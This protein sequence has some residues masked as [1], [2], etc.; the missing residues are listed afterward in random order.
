MFN[1]EYQKLPKVATSPTRAKLERLDGKGAYTFMLNP[2]LVQQDHK[3]NFSELGVLGTAQPQVVY[4]N[5]GTTLRL[6]G[7][8]ITTPGQGYSLEVLIGTLQSFTVP[9]VPGGSPPLLKFTYGKLLVPRCYLT[10]LSLTSSQWRSGDTVWAEA[11]MVLLYAPETPAPQVSKEVKL[12]P[13]EQEGN[14]NNVKIQL[15]SETEQKKWAVSP[16]DK[17]SID[18]KGLVSAT[19]SQGKTRPVGDFRDITEGK[20]RPGLKK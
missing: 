11:N 17:L 2:S 8:L 16:K 6:P 7:V 4:Q 20:V 12:S 5:S 10:E 3:A 1:P 9:I 19:D 18:E 14:L 13:R 15:S